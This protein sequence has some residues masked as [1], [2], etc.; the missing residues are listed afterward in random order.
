MFESI[1]KTEMFDANEFVELESVSFKSN[2][3]KLELIHGILKQGKSCLYIDPDIVFLKN[4]LEYLQSE[5]QNNDLIIVDK[6]C[7]LNSAFI[8][9]D[10]DSAHWNASNT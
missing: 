1:N 7:C 4:P 8:S 6:S 10:I 2:Y 9:N 3:E 5:I